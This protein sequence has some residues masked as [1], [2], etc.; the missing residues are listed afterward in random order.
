MIVNAIPRD[1]GVELREREYGVIW[2]VSV[3]LATV[4]DCGA[5]N[6]I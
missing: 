1:K 4:S 2:V 6:S 3:G 5:G